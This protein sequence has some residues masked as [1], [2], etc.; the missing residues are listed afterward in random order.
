LAEVFVDV[1]GGSVQIN[2]L[3]DYHDI[4]GESEKGLI[5][6]EK[7]PKMNQEEIY[8]IITNKN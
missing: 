3:K 4:I 6:S 7:C 8:E 1:Y 2:N 5:S